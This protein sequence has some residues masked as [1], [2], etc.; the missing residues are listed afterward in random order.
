MPGYTFTGACTDKCIENIIVPP[1]NCRVHPN[2]WTLFNLFLI[3]P[4]LLY[5]LQKKQT[6]TVWCLFIVFVCLNR[7]FDILDGGVARACDMTSK[8]GA[9]LDIFADMLLAVGVLGVVL[10]MWNRSK[11][12]SFLG[13]LLLIV[14]G[15]SVIS[16]IAQFVKEMLS[17]KDRELYVLESLV[18]DNSFCIFLIF[19][20]IVKLII[21]Y[22]LR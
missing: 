4:L 14:F 11:Q 3:T 15:V 20:I 19:M 12:I 17:Q 1:I 22:S 10:V 21:E 9:A 8:S 2:V 16:H 7:M 6:I 18:A 13:T 5:F